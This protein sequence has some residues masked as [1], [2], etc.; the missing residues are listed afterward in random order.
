MKAWTWGAVAVFA[1]ALTACGGGGNNDD[2]NTGGN[3]GASSS[4]TMGTGSPTSTGTNGAGGGATEC[5]S[6]QFD[7]EPVCQD[8]MEAACCVE[9]N[10]CDVGTPC[11]E[12]VNCI[13]TDKCQDQACL[14]NCVMKAGG[15]G[16]EFNA[17]ISCYQGSCQ[18]ECTPAG[19]CG[20]QYSYPN[21]ADCNTCLTNSCCDSFNACIAD[22]ACVDCLTNSSAMGCDTNMLFQTFMTCRT[23]SC[24]ATCGVQICDSS[25]VLT[26][27]KAPQCGTCLSTNCCAEYNACA[28]GSKCAMCLTSATPAADCAQDMAYSA[29][30]MCESMKC[31]MDCN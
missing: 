24:G 31:Q 28:S 2:G 14:N 13:E 11:N 26:G 27:P 21:K 22:M 1:A 6:Y 5:G 23:G 8:C 10:D 9:L 19:I 16:M 18:M 3:G 15:G 7:P 25:W 12:V 30:T 17:L 29:L 20:S 4:S